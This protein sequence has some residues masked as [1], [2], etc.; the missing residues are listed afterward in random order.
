MLVSAF[1]DFRSLGDVGSPSLELD[2]VLAQATALR[3]IRGYSAAEVRERLVRARDLAQITGSGEKRFNIEWGLFQHSIVRAD[4]DEA[5]RIASSLY[6]LAERHPERPIVDAYLADGMV[7]FSLGEFERAR[8]MFE[9]GLELSNPETDEPHFLTHGQNPGLFCLSYLAHTLCFLGYHD[10]AKSAIG[11]SIAIAQAR[12]R[13]PAHIYGYVNALTF[14][15]RVHQFCGDI[16]S[17]RQLAEKIVDISKRNHYTYY[18]ALS[19]CHLGWVTGAEGRLSEGI[20]Q[21]VGGIAALERAGTILALP[22]F[23]TLLAELYIRARRLSEA[24]AVLSQAVNLHGLLIWGAEIERLRGDILLSWPRP[25]LDAAESA[26]RASLTIADRQNARSLM[27]KAG[28]NLSRVLQRT[29]RPH[30]AREILEGCVAR[31]PDGFNSEEAQSA[32]MA[33]SALKKES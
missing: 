15:V 31:L 30:E 16:A 33:I 13:E 2:L 9:K 22:G 28:L 4:S 26:Y 10:L 23:Y 25:N 7:A 6:E 8:E 21:M 3:S 14:A 32:R 24:D 20:D 19:S 17:E 29:G 12:A 11:R 5:H 27:L 1:D 18:E